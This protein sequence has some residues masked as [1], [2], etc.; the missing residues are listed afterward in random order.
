MIKAAKFWNKSARKYAASKISDPE[1]YAHKL[2]QTAQ[3]YS[4]ESILLEFGCG[5]GT[6]A[7]HHAPHVAS[8]LALDISPEMIAIAK[9]KQ[10]AA[11]ITNVDFRVG[12]LDT[13]P[14]HA[15]HYDMVMAHSIL[16]L[17]E[18]PKGAIARFHQILKPGGYLVSST[19]CLKSGGLLFS[20][21]VPVMQLFGLAPYVNLFTKDTLKTW[22]EEAGF[23]LSYVWH[24]DKAKMVQFLI[25]K[26]L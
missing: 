3:H 7:L 24:S 16:H 5:T 12:G 8:I 11:G 14:S 18:D 25:A 13:I 1:A 23:E 9:E 19:A 26:K 2:A 17:I 15:D 21:L 6:T 10:T 4:A 20:L 22:H